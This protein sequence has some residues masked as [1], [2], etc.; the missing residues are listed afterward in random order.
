MTLN[1]EQIIKDSY[2]DHDRVPTQALKEIH[3]LPK[4]SDNLISKVNNMME[5]FLGHIQKEEDELF[6]MVRRS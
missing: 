3:A 4:D 1:C 5:D 6:A 2:E